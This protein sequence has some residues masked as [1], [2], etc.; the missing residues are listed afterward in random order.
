LQRQLAD[1]NPVQAD[2]TR[3]RLIEAQDQLDQAALAAARAADEGHAAA[4]LDLE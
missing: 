2:A 1:R 3:L 4:R